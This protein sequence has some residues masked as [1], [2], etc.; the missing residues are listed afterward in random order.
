MQVYSTEA[1]STFDLIKELYKTIHPEK[2]KY[3][4]Y[5]E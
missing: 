1:Y 3:L 5:N 4:K 2:K